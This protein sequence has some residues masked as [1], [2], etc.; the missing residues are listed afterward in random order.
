MYYLPLTIDARRI[1]VCKLDYLVMPNQNG[2]EDEASF[3]ALNPVFGFIFS[4]NVLFSTYKQNV[5]LIP[6]KNKKLEGYNI[7]IKKC[8]NDYTKYGKTAPV[9]FFDI[10]KRS[11]N[12]TT[13]NDENNN[14]PFHIDERKHNFKN[15][16]YAIR[17]KERNGTRIA[18]ERFVVC[19][20]YFERNSDVDKYK[21]VG[22]LHLSDAPIVL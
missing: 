2:N 16:G 5:F 20:R 9:Y 8:S 17:F 19:I 1:H 15:G 12:N 3:N 18:E 21:L 10:D 14:T 4:S 6:D 7:G 13:K 11:H 22:S